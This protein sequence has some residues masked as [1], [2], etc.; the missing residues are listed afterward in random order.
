MPNRHSKLNTHVIRLRRPW[1]KQ[2]GTTAE[3][4]RIDVP[5]PDVDLVADTAT[6]QRRFN[7]PGSLEPTDIVS[8]EV[9]SWQ[10]ELIAICINDQTLNLPSATENQ[11]SKLDVTNWLKD[12]NQIEI[13]IRPSGNQ[14]PRLSGAVNLLIESIAITESPDA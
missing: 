14:P 4:I 7:R 5:E 6:Y 13:Q 11:T 3:T 9:Q 8:I 1:S 12:H 2:T 10:G